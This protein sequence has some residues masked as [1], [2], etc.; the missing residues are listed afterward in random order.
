MEKSNTEKIKDFLLY[1]PVGAF[2]FVKDNAPTFFNMFVSRGKRDV[3]KS[4][5]VAEEKIAESREKGQIVAM[6]TPIA[7]E[8][9]EQL[10][11]EAKEKGESFASSAAEV[12]GAA[13]SVAGDFLSS[14]VEMITTEDTNDKSNIAPK[15]E[16][17]TDSNDSILPDELKAE[18][19]ALSAPEI[20]DM[21]GNF[22]DDELLVIQQY[23]S[24]FRN[25]QTI[26]HAIGHRLNS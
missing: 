18:Y 10:K 3:N 4:A 16:P 11:N 24:S 1:A 14:I 9:A 7:K 23:E 15:P 5:M 8:H 25:R 22:S 26:I 20:I 21:L 12:A 2:G 6:G 17:K 13:L 19:D